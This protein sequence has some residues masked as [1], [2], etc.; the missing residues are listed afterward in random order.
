MILCARAPPCP[1]SSTYTSSPASSPENGTSCS[2]ANMYT[3]WSCCCSCLTCL[4]DLPPYTLSMFTHASTLATKA[5]MYGCSRSRTSS[6]LC[7]RH[8]Y[9]LRMLACA[10]RGACRPACRRLRGC[11]K[12]TC[13]K[14][15]PPC[16]PTA[17]TRQAQ[18]A[19]LAP[20]LQKRAASCK[21]RSVARHRIQ[22]H[23]WWH[24]LISQSTFLQA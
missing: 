18:H 2:S 4:Q 22:T 1:K 23:A 19:L 20:C 5:T 11:A 8:R 15:Q 10:C 24:H 16:P 21:N 14:H 17:Q 12:G 7:P 6:Y 3:T 9:M 13:R